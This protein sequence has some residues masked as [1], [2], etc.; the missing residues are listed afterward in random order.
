[1]PHLLARS[2][3]GGLQEAAIDVSLFPNNLFKAIQAFAI[4]HFKF[5]QPLLLPNSKAIP[6]LLRICYTCTPLPRTKICMS[7]GFFREIN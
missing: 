3:M 4:V 1:M 7:S 2:S 5:V 6:T